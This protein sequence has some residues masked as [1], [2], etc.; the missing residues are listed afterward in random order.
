MGALTFLPDALVNAAQFLQRFQR[1]ARAASALNHPNISTIYAV[2]EHDGKPFIAMELL[3]GQTLSQRI[4]A[5]A[6]AEQKRQAEAD[7]RSKAEPPPG[8]FGTGQ[9]R[10]FALQLT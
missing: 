6:R 5:G 9:L 3:E 1:E 2:E 7:T 10:D 8:P 4:A